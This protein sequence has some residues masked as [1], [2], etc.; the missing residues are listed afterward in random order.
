MLAP[1]CNWCLKKK[2]HGLHPDGYRDRTNWL[3]HG[4][5]LHSQ[6]LD[7]RVTPWHD[8]TYMNRYERFSQPFRMDRSYF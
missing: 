6:Y 4:M 8:P 7:C 5:A 1:I 3:R 2:W